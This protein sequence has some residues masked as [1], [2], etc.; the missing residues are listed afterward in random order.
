[1]KNLSVHEVRET[2]ERIRRRYPDQPFGQ[3]WECWGVPMG[4]QWGDSKFLG[5]KGEMEHC[6][7]KGMKPTRYHGSSNE[8]QS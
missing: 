2:C 5:M 8:R 1:M 3:H 6:A 4:D 7:G